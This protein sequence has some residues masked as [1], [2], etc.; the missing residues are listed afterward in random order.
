M[1]D[2]YAAVIDYLAFRRALGFKLDRAEQPLNS[3]VGFLA[4]EHADRITIDLALRWATLPVDADPWWWSNRLGVVRGFARYVHTIDPAHDV[5][6]AGLI[7]APPP[8]ATPYMFTE[9][10]ITAL[11]VAARCLEPVLRGRTY[12]TLIGML[13]VTG[14]R[15][16]EALNL[17]DNDVDL[18]HGSITIRATKF[19]KTRANPI[20]RSTVEALDRYRRDRCRSQTAPTTASFFVSTVGTRLCYSNVLGVFHQLIDEVGLQ[21]RRG[22]Q[23]PRMHDLRHRFA[24]QSILDAYA[25]GVDVGPR[26]AALSTYLGHGR[27]ADTYWYL[28]ATPELLGRAAELLDNTS[29]ARS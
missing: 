29:G 17:D 1:T 13:A 5:P 6:P 22:G 27:P 10:N 11:M 16:S 15:V 9:D 12:T 24:V 14:M 2:L 23:R 20:H 7:C 8:R 18:A 28:S 4:A 19:D 3:F 26:F 21:E 25:A